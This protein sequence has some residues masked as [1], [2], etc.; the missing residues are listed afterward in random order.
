MENENV[1]RGIFV[2]MITVILVLLFAVIIIATHGVIGYGLGL[3][4]ISIPYIGPAIVSGVSFNVPVVLALLPYVVST[5]SH[6]IK[7]TL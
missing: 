6:Y 3:F 1:V 4:I 2:W 7:I 5:V